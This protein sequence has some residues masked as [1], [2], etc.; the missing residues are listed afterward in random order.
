MANKSTEEIRKVTSELSA[1]L[2]RELL[3]SDSELEFQPYPH[4]SDNHPTWR[5]RFDL[6]MNSRIQG[7]VELNGEVILGRE[8]PVPGFVELSQTADPELYGVSR[9]HA[10]LRPTESKLYLIDLGSTNGTWI[11]GH[12][13]GV[14]MPY[15]L[16]NG[17]IVRL[18]R[19][20]FTISILGHPGRKAVSNRKTD[21]V[22]ILPIIARS[23]TT[24]LDVKEVLKQ[25]LTAAM[26]Y[27]PADEVSIWLVD[28]QSGELFLEAGQGMNHEQ[29]QRLPV[30]DTLAGQVVRTGKPALVNREKDGGQIKL[31]TGY[32]VEAVIYV[33]LTLGGA[34]FG[35]LSAAHRESGKLF[36]QEDQKLLAAIADFTAVAIQNARQY[37]ATSRKLMRSTKIFTALNY[38]LSSD[39]KSLVNTI[40]G[41]A[42]M[43]RF[44]ETLSEDLQEILLQLAQN[45]DE[46]ANLIHKM[47]EIA[48]LTMDIFIQSAPFDLEEVVARAVAE[49]QSFA[50]EKA[51]QLSFQVMGTP[52]LILG[53]EGYMYRSTLNL[54]DNAIRYSP[55]ESAV[56]VML[57]YSH[58][59]VILGV[60][61]TGPGIPEN[62]LPYL[63]ER[64]VRGEQSTGF[65]L[66][67]EL[68]RTVVEA[69]RGS[70]TACNVPDRGAEL[71]IVLPGTLR[72]G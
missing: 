27:A 39:L 20:E 65:G 56:S 35:V 41:Y 50:G 47:T 49:M 11:N 7:G 33:P 16:S 70:V 55:P 12:S 68:V 8:Q 23:I 43:L 69:H 22:D 63:F 21:P 15:S 2:L 29:I 66:G 18:G 3:D 38:V 71:K 36:S 10:L 44:E 31:K 17:D 9:R 24:Q 13:I 64:F 45:G 40:I 57:V 30:A 32:L 60:R 46:T 52:Y 48:N 51:T 72:V 67:L 28:E 37:Q 62:D 58:K 6:T 1:E 54:I 34:T 4:T 19:M 26:T 42:G 59:E 5:L 61:D 53:D 25:A 14:N